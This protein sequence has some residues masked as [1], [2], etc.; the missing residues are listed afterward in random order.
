MVIGTIDVEPSFVVYS[1]RVGTEDTGTDR[2][3]AA[4]ILVGLCNALSTRRHHQK[5]EHHG[6]EGP[7]CSKKRNSFHLQHAYFGCKVTR[8]RLRFQI[9]AVKNYKILPLE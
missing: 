6:E 2:I 9:F 3:S 5:C 1:R 7:A 8:Q 4:G